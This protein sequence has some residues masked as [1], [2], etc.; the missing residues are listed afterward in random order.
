MSQPEV[1]VRLACVNQLE[2]G[3]L[4]MIVKVGDY[5][6]QTLIPKLE[7]QG[8]L[9]T[10]EE[11]PVPMLTVAA[12]T[13][14]KRLEMTTQLIRT[15]K[16]W[17]DECCGYAETTCMLRLETDLANFEIIRHAPSPD[18]RH[19]HL[20]LLGAKKAVALLMEDYREVAKLQLEIDALAAGS[21]A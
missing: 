19:M 21:P 13:W 6:P 2:V 5:L 7:E 17:H 8:F 14:I 1:V 15:I 9:V 11:G 20:G 10:V 18:S 12:K 3:F 4:V 16:A